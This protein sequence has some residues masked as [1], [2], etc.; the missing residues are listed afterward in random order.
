[1]KRIL[2]VMV[3][4]VFASSLAFADSYLGDGC[5]IPKDDL[6]RGGKSGTGEEITIKTTGEE[7]VEPDGTEGT[8]AEGRTQEEQVKSKEAAKEK[9][10]IMNLIFTGLFDYSDAKDLLFAGLGCGVSIK[11]YDDGFEAWIRLLYQKTWPFDISNFSAEDECSKTTA[12]L[13]S[14]LV[15]DAGDYTLGIAPGIFYRLI[16]HPEGEYSEKGICLEGF[17]RVR[18]LKWLSFQPAVDVKFLDPLEIGFSVHALVNL[19]FPVRES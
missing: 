7:V 6:G 5:V 4:L 2:I 3:V 13:S 11:A 8:G 9:R 17:T 15:F 16:T 1:M 18:L 10:N 14:E 19:R 12:I